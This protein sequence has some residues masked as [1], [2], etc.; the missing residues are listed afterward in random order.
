MCEF[1]AMS[2]K[3]RMFTKVKIIKGGVRTERI[4]DLFVDEFEPHRCGKSPLYHRG[5]LSPGAS[6]AKSSDGGSMLGSWA[7]R[8]EMTPHEAAARGGL[9]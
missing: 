5:E 6:I 8:G 9:F 2:M 7:E 1:I 4:V 3:W